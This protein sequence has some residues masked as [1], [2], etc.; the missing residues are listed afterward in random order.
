MF[1]WREERYWYND[2][3]GS[4]TRRSFNVDVTYA[5]L[6]SVAHDCAVKEMRYDTV[7]SM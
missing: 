5:D 6:Q 7:K 1:V 4:W 2:Q 3:D